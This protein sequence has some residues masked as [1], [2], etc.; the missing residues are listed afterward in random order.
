MSKIYLSKIIIYNRAPFADRVEFNFEEN[1]VATFGGINGKGKTT[2]MSYIVDAFV[3]M[4]RKSFFNE[5]EKK[6]NK[7]Y[8]VSS[9]TY[10][11]NYKEPSL[12][13]IRFVYGEK[14]I[15]YVDVRNDTKRILTAE[16]YTEILKLQDCIN[17]NSLSQD[18]KKFQCIKHLSIPLLSNESEDKIISDI[19][20]SNIITYFPTYRSE[21][22]GYL[23]EEYKIEIKHNFKANF[24]GYLQNDVEVRSGLPGFINWLLDFF[25][26]YNIYRPKLKWN[27]SISENLTE[28]SKNNFIG[29]WIEFQPMENLHGI[30][31][32]IITNILSSKYKNSKIGF[33]IDSRNS[34]TRRININYIKQDYQGYSRGETIY[35]NIFNLSSGEADLLTIFGNIIRQNDNIK[36]DANFEYFTGIVIIDEIDKHLHISLQKEVL[37]RLFNLFPNIQFIIS[38]QS[39]FVSLGLADLGKNRK[40]QNRGKIKC[41]DSGTDLEPKKIPELD[42]VYNI[43]MP[44][45]EKLKQIVEDLN[46]Q[47]QFQNIDNQPVIITEGKTDW[48]YMIKALEYF[49][50]KNEF[51]IIQSNYFLRFG[52]DDD[53]SNNLYGT[54]IISEMGD[55]TLKNLLEN[56]IK[57]RKDLIIP[58][59]TE[60]K[61]IGYFDSDNCDKI[62]SLT[63]SNNVYKITL[64]KQDSSTEHLFEHKDITKTWKINK[65][66]LFFGFE[67]DTISRQTT[68]TTTLGNKKQKFNL[69]GNNNN[70]NKAGKNTVVDSCVFNSNGDDIALSKNEFSKNIYE[71]KI[72]ISNESWEN[73]QPI[74]EMIVKIIRES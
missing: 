48:R 54:K 9:S 31:N 53:V 44:D 10:T 64:H 66:R 60:N 36:P 32:S 26:D 28:D 37:P 13:Y 63:D 47:I 70:Y 30:L 12:V 16:R 34:G 6:I 29:Q 40:G 71:E 62:K 56:K 25:L 72:K 8:R 38:S 43:L 68:K 1:E 11:I 4:A 22:P 74:F 18:P 41:L 61:I 5:Y 23:N 42:T 59:I 20:N 46:N 15:D 39:P 19:F 24:S 45:Y 14:I 58:D 17:I 69:A 52:S 55:T 67:F 50:K 35:P 33:G 3:E 73:F 21:Q 49:H 27:P 7:F 2:I 51:L 57:L 65:K